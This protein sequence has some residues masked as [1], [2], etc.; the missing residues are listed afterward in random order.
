MTDPLCPPWKPSDSSKSWG[1]PPPPVMTDF[2]LYLPSK[3]MW[4][5]KVQR[6]HSSSPLVMTDPSLPPLKTM[7]TPP[8]VLRYPPPLPERWI[9]TGP[10]FPHLK[11]LR[12]W[13]YLN[14]LHPNIS[15][16]ILHTFLYIFTGV[17][18]RRICQTIKSFLS[19]WSFPLI[20]WHESLNQG[21]YGKEKLDAGHSYKLK[22]WELSNLFCAN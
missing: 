7:W 17:M 3:T 16:H 12:L 4:S 1:N 2:P 14:P 8:R 9:R 13:L 5:P 6:H 21:W 10:L 11:Q 15:M 18:T 19:C 22:G 20:S